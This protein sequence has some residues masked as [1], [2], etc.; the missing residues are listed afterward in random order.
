MKLS[1]DPSVDALYM[2]LIDEP[3]ECEVLPHQR[4]SSA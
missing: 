1:Y 2:R 4:S 3:A